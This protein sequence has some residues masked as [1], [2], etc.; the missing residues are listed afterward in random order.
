MIRSLIM[1]LLLT[2]ALAAAENLPIDPA[3]PAGSRSRLEKFDRQLGSL[4]KDQWRT[5]EKEHQN[6]IK[7]ITR[8]EE[9]RA[10]AEASKAVYEERFT[11]P[12]YE[13]GSA[14]PPAIALDPDNKD[15]AFTTRMKVK[16]FAKSRDL[17]LANYL[18]EIEEQHALMRAGLENDL[19]RAFDRGDLRGA[20][21]L[22]QL[23]LDIQASEQTYQRRLK[24]QATV[25]THSALAHADNDTAALASTSAPQR[26]TKPVASKAQTGFW[27]SLSVQE[28][29]L[30]TI[31]RNSGSPAAFVQACLD[32][33]PSADPGSA[34]RSYLVHRLAEVGSEG[35]SALCGALGKQ[36]SAFERAC[37]LVV[38]DR[39]ATDAHQQIV[40]DAYATEPALV[41]LIVDRQWTRA[42]LPTARTWLAAEGLEQAGHAQIVIAE[43]QADD[44]PALVEACRGGTNL[45]F[46]YGDLMDLNGFPLQEAEDAAWAAT[47][48]KGLI[49]DNGY[50]YIGHG[51][52]EA[53]DALIEAG[54]HPANSFAGRRIVWTLRRY[55]KAPDGAGL[56]P[57]I[58]WYDR[59]KE[60][61]TFDAD[62]KIWQ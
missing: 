25:V 21:A 40:L 10:A 53:L 22:D 3:L 37:L 20:Q 43:G 4:L 62:K 6:L 7:K 13:D 35:L 58:A 47:L 9:V 23:L 61:L 33:A 52:R 28:E 56:D 54:R 15:L 57:M 44:Y 24:E 29:P 18:R 2:T 48:A 12:W 16:L 31:D 59:R 38:I 1:T 36:R 50:I 60:Q 11:V 42:A 51:K 27:R 41:D 26:S 55:T 34:R 8:D 30:A 46:I 19:A 39:L 45:H 32:A 14:T 5:L 17:L 49:V